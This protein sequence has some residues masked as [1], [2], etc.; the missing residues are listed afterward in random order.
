MKEIKGI[1]IRKAEIKF[2]LFADNKVLYRE[3]PPKMIRNLLELTNDFS[4]ETGYK[5]KSTYRN[6]WYTFTLIMKRWKTKLKENYPTHNS[7]KSIEIL[8]NECIQGS[9]ISIQ[10]KLQNFAERNWRCH[11]YIERHPVF[12]YWINIVKMDIL[13]RAIY[14]FNGIAIKIPKHSSQK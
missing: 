6:Q 3:N 12:M 4:E 11:E 14:G 5:I 8:R 13:L 2:L 10:W 9:E 1:Q 7:I